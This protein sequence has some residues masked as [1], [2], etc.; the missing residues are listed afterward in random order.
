MEREQELER[1]KVMERASREKERTGKVMERGEVNFVLR[2]R[3]RDRG[4]K[5]PA[6]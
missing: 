1:G 6:N 5:T 2:R 3:K 4:S